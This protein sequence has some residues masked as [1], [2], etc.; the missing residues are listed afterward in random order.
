MSSL[1]KLEEEI[2]AASGAVAAGDTTP[3]AFT[4]TD[5]TNVALSTTITSAAITVSGI[6]TPTGITVSGG[7]Y[8]IN[9][10]G[11][12]TSSPGTVNNGDTV[13]ARHTSSGSNSTAA[14]TV[15]TIGGVSDTFTSTTVA[16][17]FSPIDVD[18]TTGSGAETAPSGATQVVIKVNG[19]G[20]NGQKNTSP[21]PPGT[22]GGGGGN[23]VKTLAVSGG[24]TFNYNASSGTKTVTTGSGP[25][26]SLS[27]T[28]GNH[29][30]AGGAGGTGSGGDT[31]TSGLDG[32][33]PTGGSSPNGGAI[34]PALGGAGNSPGGG[35]GGNT[36]SG[37]P[38]GTGAF[39]R[40]RFSY[41]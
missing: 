22:G 19:D 18:Y 21:G 38:G 17:G 13:R 31:N 16:S 14:N 41:T 2:L 27:V 10:S 7:T 35:G 28:S 6:D 29:G 24:Q 39:G 37:G 32:A 9:G 34:Q 25:A 30:I 15:V 33:Q 12:F 40:I 23:S 3:N 4:F 1:I 26:V 5:Q 11:S 20:G 8:D 36:L